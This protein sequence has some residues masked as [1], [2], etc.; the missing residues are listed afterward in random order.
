M[1]D[2]I[3]EIF[4]KRMFEPYPRWRELT[5]SDIPD[6]AR[7]ICALFDPI[8]DEEW[9]RRQEESIASWELT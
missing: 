5:P 2:K 8:D 1:E 7:E 3:I 6:I 9:E 4:E